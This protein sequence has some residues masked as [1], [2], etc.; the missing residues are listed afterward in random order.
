VTQAIRFALRKMAKNNAELSNLLAP[1]IRTGTVCSYVP[2]GNFP[3][4]WRL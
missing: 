3:V 2:A 4:R 1:T